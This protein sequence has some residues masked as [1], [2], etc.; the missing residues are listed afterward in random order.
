MIFNVT[1]GGG[2]T[3]CTL[4]ITA[5]VGATV[6]IS[7]DGKSKPSKV[8]TTGTVVFKGLE[9]G[10]WTITITNGT[11]TATKTVEVKADYSAEITFFSAT[12]NIVYP[13]G[14]A[15]TVTDGVTTLAAPDTSGTWACEVSNDGKWTIT[16][17]EWSGEVDIAAT[18][19]TETVR[20]AKWIVKNGVP[21]DIGLATQLVSGRIPTITQGDGYTTIQITSSQSTG[22]LSNSPVDMTNVKTIIAD[23]NIVK[24][25]VSSGV[26]FEGVVLI[27]TASKAYSS[28]DNAKNA[29]VG[30]SGST[31]TGRQKL[32]IDAGSTTGSLY[33]GFA[34]GGIITVNLYD[35]RVEV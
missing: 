27:S 8:A 13:A 6:T 30:Q 1:G 5:P 24:A 28:V 10:T 23:V 19:Q 11:D 34:L 35:L 14:L 17:G 3:G 32:S 4:T 15:C 31:S 21:T 18:G 9:T 16:A 26:K 33:V 7:K 2:G 29:I 20:L 12:I 22:V 25:T